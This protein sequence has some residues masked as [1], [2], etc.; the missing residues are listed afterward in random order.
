VSL[1]EQAAEMARGEVTCVAATEITLRSI[2]ASQ[3]RVNAFLTID[4]D[5]AM[6]A[7]AE[8][9]S[10]RAR[11]APLGALHGVP[12]A[13]KD[14]FDRVGHRCSFG[15][16]IQQT[17]PALIDAA[18]VDRLQRAGG[19]ALGALNMSEFALGPTGHNS[20]F[21][22]CRNPH[23][24][25]R[26]SGGSSSGSAAAV[27]AGLVSGALGSDTGG[28]IRLPA[29]CCGVTGLK[30]TQYAISATGAMPLSPSMDCV[31]PIALTARD[32]AAL[33]QVLTDCQSPYPAVTRLRVAYPSK[34]I[35]ATSTPD[36]AEAIDEA[37]S[38][39]V[40]WGAEVI[41]RPIPNLERLHD[42][43]EVIQK[44]E[45]AA[46]HLQGLRDN[47]SQ[48]SRH[49]R[50]R[51]EGGLIMSAVP[52]AQA[53]MQRANHL[54][55]FLQTSLAQADILIIPTIGIPVPLIINTDEE[56]HGPLPEIFSGMTRWTRWLN[57]LGVPALS[58]PCGLDGAGMPIGMQIVGRP[59]SE[60]ALLEVGC[61][62]Q[63]LA[64]CPGRANLAR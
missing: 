49:I 37:I 8:A 17:E 32:C 50:R 31:G 36:I 28:S 30:P 7:A 11:G 41:E 56:V 29:S 24:P 3:P 2:I 10:R 45:S 22:V 63:S 43:A 33:Y 20:T 26:I 25:A 13:Y 54:E 48:Y 59:L 18:A 5:A 21:G 1:I 16:R 52:Y 38:E 51:I 57:Y 58:V 19:I 23:D 44:S 34:A 9:D 62:Y 4:S 39:L 15:S 60:S 53:L 12:L 64:G 27:A 40:R 55:N 47:R 42:L 46:L 14:M 6:S 61:L 35:A